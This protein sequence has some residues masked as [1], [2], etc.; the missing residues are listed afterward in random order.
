[1]DKKHALIK[2]Q[3]GRYFIYDMNSHYGT[4][5]EK[6]RIPPQQ[7]IE[8]NDGDRISFSPE[9]MYEFK[10]EKPKVR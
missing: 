2:E 7:A 4:Y 8:L 6:N 3:G 9:I 10:I 5:V 1:M